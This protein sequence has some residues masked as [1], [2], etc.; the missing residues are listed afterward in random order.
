LV[1]GSVAAAQHRA[2]AV[3]RPGDVLDEEL[4]G[5]VICATFS[6]ASSREEGLGLR[7]EREELACA[8][9]ARSWAYNDAD[10]ERQRQA[11]QGRTRTVMGF[12]ERE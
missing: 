7:V 9:T 4:I 10:D 8:G 12:P 3:S 5:C 6:S 11:G 1:F 2:K